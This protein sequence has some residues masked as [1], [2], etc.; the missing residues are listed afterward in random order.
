[1]V[2]GVSSDIP[3]KSKGYQLDILNS[4]GRKLTM[5]HLE[6][7]FVFNCTTAFIGSHNPL[8]RTTLLFSQVSLR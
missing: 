7:L 1:M 4:L 5:H 8:L 6:T 2:E 3:S